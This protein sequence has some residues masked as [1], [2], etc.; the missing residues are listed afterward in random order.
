MKTIEVEAMAHIR[1]RCGLDIHR[2]EVQE[3]VMV[4]EIKD[5]TGRSVT[6]AAEDLANA[7]C[8]QE[9]ISPH[10]LLW[11]E[12]YIHPK[13]TTYDVAIFD[14]DWRQNRF[15]HPRWRPCT[16]DEVKLVRSL[17]EAPSDPRP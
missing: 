1:T 11:I 2:G 13:E 9:K 3:I 10:K 4:T 8:Q 6:N 12:R 17:F 7:I 5:N 15:Y 16:E 14:W